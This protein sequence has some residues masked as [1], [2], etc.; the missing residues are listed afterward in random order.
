MPEATFPEWDVFQD[1]GIN[2]FLISGS[3]IPNITPAKLD[4]S[5]LQTISERC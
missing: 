2:A 1:L 4:L 5:I 3:G